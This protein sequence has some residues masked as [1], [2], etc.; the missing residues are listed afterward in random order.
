[1]YIKSTVMFTN[2]VSYI[3]NAKAVM[4]FIVFGRL[5]I[6][7][8]IICRVADRNKLISLLHIKINFY[9]FMS[10]DLAAGFYGVVKSIGKNNS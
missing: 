10:A 2:S 4:S 3:V 5:K 1:M 7:I 9:Y 6:S 8:Y